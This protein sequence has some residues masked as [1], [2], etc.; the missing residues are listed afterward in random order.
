M[1]GEESNLRPIG[2][3]FFIKK[4]L[5]CRT[6]DCT[7]AEISLY[8]EIADFLATAAPAKILAFKP[9]AATQERLEFLIW[10]KKEGNLSDQEASELLHYLMLEHI[11]R[12]A[13]ARAAIQ[14][15][16]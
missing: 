12:L 14:N 13:K 16:V 15:A 5:F 4:G 1:S 6:F 10:R 11:L 8:D 9:S 2:F 3:G 7:M